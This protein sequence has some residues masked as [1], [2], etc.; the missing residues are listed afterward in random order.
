MTKELTLTKG[1]VA[2]VDDDDYPYLSRWKWTYSG[3]YG[4]RKEKRGGKAYRIMLHRQIVNAPQ[5]YDVDHWD[6]NGLN[7]CRSNLRVSTRSQNSANRKIAT[8][9]TSQ[10]KGVCLRCDRIQNPWRASVGYNNQRINVGV[11]ASEIEAAMA[12]DAKARELFGE[13]A[14]TNFPK[15]G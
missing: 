7:N 13:F 5:G 6:G 12:Y 9:G 4:L 8:D 11:F 1:F 14:L 3:G 2:L 15:S 10:Y